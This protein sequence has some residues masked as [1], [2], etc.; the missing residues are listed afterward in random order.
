MA[1]E[2]M[3]YLI[4]ETKDFEG[5]VIYQYSPES[6]SNRFRLCY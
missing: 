2:A 6:F 5:N 1:V 4:E 3:K